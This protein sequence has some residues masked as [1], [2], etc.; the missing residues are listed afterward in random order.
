MP[1]RFQK[2]VLNWIK[3][4]V[5]EELWSKIRNLLEATQKTENN[6]AIIHSQALPPV[7]PRKRDLAVQCFVIGFEVIF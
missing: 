2:D 5:N 7:P 6:I 4:D 3:R 1:F